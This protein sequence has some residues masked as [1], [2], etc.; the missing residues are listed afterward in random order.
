M[1]ET[2]ERQPD[3]PYVPIIKDTPEGADGWERVPFDP[4]DYG[5]V[6]DWAHDLD[7]A[8]PYYNANAPAIWKERRVVKPIKRRVRQ[9]GGAA[10]RA[11]RRAP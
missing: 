11:V 10:R 4:A 2:V 8:D 9:A 6:S 5:P 7:H 3:E 1:T